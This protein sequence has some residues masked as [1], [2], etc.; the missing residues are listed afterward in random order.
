MLESDPDVPVG[1]M[2]SAHDL[3][4]DM[5]RLQAEANIAAMARARTMTAMFQ[6]FES[7]VEARRAADP[8]FTATPLA[9]TITETQPVTGQTSGRIRPRSRRC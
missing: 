7:D 6:Q 8:Y 4:I 1:V 3:L 5:R 9:E 2:P